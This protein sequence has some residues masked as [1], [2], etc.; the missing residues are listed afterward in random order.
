MKRIRDLIA[1]VL[2]GD[3][4]HSGL[5]FE[6]FKALSPARVDGQEWSPEA[7]YFAWS[8]GT[9]LRLAD[10]PD[11]WEDEPDANQGPSAWHLAMLRKCVPPRVVKCLEGDYQIT[12]AMDAAQRWTKG[13][14]LCLSGESGVGKSVAAGWLISR[15]PLGPCPFTQ[16]Q[17]HQ[18][19]AYWPHGPRWTRATDLAR[20]F[21]ELPGEVRRASVL[22]IDD[23][24]DEKN[25]E[26]SR[27]RLS[28]LL[29]ERDD[30]QARTVITT[31]LNS[32][33]LAH[34]YGV[35]FVDRIKGHGFLTSIRGETMRAR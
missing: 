21:D 20:G 23:L 18:Q 12:P 31:N 8:T 6:A 26:H 22:V 24:G 27:S 14:F 17:G 28:S 25:D 10:L 35:R 5:S 3:K 11:T 30:L 9:S 15:G 32:A 7:L 4:D 34:R 29:S 16:P 19:F 33:T 13:T 2:P 1:N